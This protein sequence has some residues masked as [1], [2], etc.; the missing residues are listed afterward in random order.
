MVLEWLERLSRNLEVTSLNPPGSLAF[1][2]FFYQRQVVLNQALKRGASLLF[3]VIT[4][5]AL[6]EAKQA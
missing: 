5:A 3:A 2:L 6:P 4:L 1:F